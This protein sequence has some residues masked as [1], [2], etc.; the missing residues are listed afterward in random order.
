MHFAETVFLDPK[1]YTS[2]DTLFKSQVIH[3]PEYFLNLT[4]S[5]QKRQFQLSDEQFLEVVYQ[6]QENQNSDFL[7]NEMSLKKETYQHNSVDTVQNFNN[8]DHSYTYDNLQI[9]QQTILNSETLEN[10][11]YESKFVGFSMS[12]LEQQSTNSTLPFKEKEEQNSTFQNQQKKYKNQNILKDIFNSFHKYVKDLKSF[13]ICEFQ[14]VDLKDVKK[15]FNRFVKIHSFNNSVIKYIL[16]HKFYKIIFIEYFEKG[17]LHN[18][19]TKSR[20]S[21][22]DGL[23]YWASYLIECIK[24]PSHL[25]NLLINRYQKK[26]KKNIQ[27]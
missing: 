4:T 9:Q 22:K 6:Q 27:G 12:N 24:Y 20:V 14:N 26:T 3:E 8:F 16:T 10:Q 19:V 15:K 23:K 5:S 7:N 17:H 21:D 25:E 1:L 18:W 2:Q 13:P 11:F